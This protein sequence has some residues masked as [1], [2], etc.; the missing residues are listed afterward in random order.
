[1]TIELPKRR[2]VRLLT[3]QS[4][5]FG[6]TMAL[7]LIT[8]NALFLDTYGA[9]WL[10]ATYIAVAIVGVAVS[11]LLARTLRRVPLVA[12]ATFTL[13][14]QAVLFLLSWLL[15]MTGNLWVSAVLVVLFP[16]AIQIG[17]VFVGGQ[18]GRLL[19][20][21]ELKELF[22][23]IV[24][25]FAVGFLAGGLAGAPLLVVLGD[26]EDLLV[27]ATV[28]QVA[29][30]GLLLVTERR[31]P[32]LRT[33]PSHGDQSDAESFSRPALR[34][35]LAHPLV[36]AII[37]YQVLS[38]VGTQLVDFV[39]FERAAN[40]YTESTDLARFLSGYT[41]LLNLVDIVFLALVAGPLLRRFG[42]RFGLL[43]N[44][45][46][47]AVAMGAMTALAFGP[48]AAG[49]SFL[50]VAGVARVTD[51]VL[52][53]GTTRT[54]INATYQLLPG[55]DRL[56]VQAVVEGAGVPIAIGLT[57]VLLLVLQVLAGD[58][59]IVVAIATVVCIAW[60]VV[61]WF[62]HRAYSVG[63]REA[64]VKRTLHESSLDLGDATEQ[65]ALAELLASDDGRRVGLGLE[66]LAGLTSPATEAELKR[67]LDDEQPNVR[68]AALAEL[69]GPA[70][71]SL[72]DAD[73][74]SLMEALDGDGD[75]TAPA[76]LRA[77]RACRSLPPEIA[78]DR[79]LRCVT[80]SDRTVGL[81]VLAA[82]AVAGPAATG[83]VDDVLEHVVADDMT[84]ARRI[85][86][87]RLDPTVASSSILMWA[88]D[89]ELELLRQRAFS[90]LVISVG[91][92]AARARRI[93]QED[94]RSAQAL[95]LEA[96]DVAVG[97]DRRPLLV[98]VRPDL[99]D[100]GRLAALGG[101]LASGPSGSRWIDDLASD[102]ADHW[103][104]EWLRLCARH[105]ESG[106]GTSAG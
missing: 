3:A 104:S 7:L 106:V 60:T 88:L 105:E 66:L 38:A 65:A 63:L 27:V 44:P 100:A 49:L 54:S 61:A 99:D 78:V 101:A 23:R 90:M 48:G 93:F 98:L 57:G 79:L 41:A 67:L 5:A 1:M 68:L 69:A 12:V 103:R 51:V 55:E 20:L 52:T 29:F 34:T 45:A 6:V 43:A 10:P 89:D 39:F 17:F 15:A 11:W 102:P 30:V 85:L 37:G 91:E 4:F 24:S 56:A 53:D 32:A 97:R 2:A 8:G 36:V 9:E 62:A 82:L 71:A 64:V 74:A 21:R 92:V 77:L 81:T 47:V 86:S 59:A 25:G 73:A 28:A 87:A 84:H 76:T 33:Q 22:P 58:T 80:H 35:L 70:G 72:A 18:A 46:F 19:D 75:L 16:L 26:T 95:A 31:F 96:L 40:R 14:A 50:A 42:L 83:E 94:N 13:G